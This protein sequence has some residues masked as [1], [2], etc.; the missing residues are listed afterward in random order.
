MASSL[1]NL[2]WTVAACAAIVAQF[3]PNAFCDAC[4]KP[5]CAVA[6]TLSAAA[7]AV[8]ESHAGCPLCTAAAGTRPAEPTEQ[9]CRCQL[10]ARHEQPLSPSRITIRV[11][12]DG[13]PAVG[14]AAAAPEVPQVLGVSREYVAESLAV[15][16]RPPR[17]LFGVWRD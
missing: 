3:A 6:G 7:D 5:C 4:S 9:P 12:A 2:V 13:D 1:R 11:V 16:I 10:D 17:I 14:P 15:P 8:A